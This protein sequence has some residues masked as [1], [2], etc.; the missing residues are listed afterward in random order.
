MA[1]KTWIEKRDCEKSFKIKTIEKKFA[2]IP[3]G[4]RMLIV[5]PPIIDAY[6]KAILTGQSVELTT[7]RNDMAIEYQADKTCPI[8]TGIF[9]RIVSE[10]AYEEFLAGKST[11]EITPFWRVVHPKMKLA[12]K[13]ACGIDFIQKQRE[14]EEIN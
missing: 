11:E 10:A 6:V 12:Q 8:T 14:L 7:M 2:D 3:E 9:L 5:S 13:L 1:K 4:S